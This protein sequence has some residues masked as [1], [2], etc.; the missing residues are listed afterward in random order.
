M[1]T[2]TRPA[3]VA[4]ASP[5]ERPTPTRSSGMDRT[6]RRK[7]ATAPPSWAWD[8]SRRSSM[9][10]SWTSSAPVSTGRGELTAPHG[11]TL[12]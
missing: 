11:P 2:I 6:I 8:T 1:G 3:E 5:T 7:A 12:P 4:R 9:S 10:A